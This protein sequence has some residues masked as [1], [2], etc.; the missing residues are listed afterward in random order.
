MPGKRPVPFPEFDRWRWNG[1]R[2]KPETRLSIKHSL[3]DPGPPPDHG[4][5]YEEYRDDIA[6]WSDEK[7]N[8]ELACFQDNINNNTMPVAMERAMREAKLARHDDL[9]NQKM[10]RFKR[11]KLFFDEIREKR[12]KEEEEEEGD[13]VVEMVATGKGGV[14]RHVVARKNVEAAAQRAEDP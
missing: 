3:P 8:G 9:E 13:T 5:S 11:N 12:V 1:D 7:L 6:T 4:I 14:Q 2:T 10:E